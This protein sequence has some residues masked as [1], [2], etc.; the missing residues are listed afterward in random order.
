MRS[1]VYQCDDEIITTR[2]VVLSFSAHVTRIHVY[3]DDLFSLQIP[4]N[5]WFL[6][7]RCYASA[8]TSH[9]PVSVCLCLSV[10]LS[11]VGILSKRMN[12]SGWV[13]ARERFFPP[14]QHCA[15]RKFRYLQ[16]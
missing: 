12:E 11:Q 16:K 10:C 5:L 3:V 13:L 9:D 8:G 14:I 2:F 4:A 7:A 1:P 15:I 6:R